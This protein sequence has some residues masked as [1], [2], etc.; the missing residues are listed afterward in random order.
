MSSS[1][2]KIK[3]IEKSGRLAVEMLRKNK[4]GMGLPF[5]INAENLP[6]TQFYYEYPDGY[7]KLVTI[8]EDRLDFKILA[9]LTMQQ[10]DD[11]RK[12]YKLVNLH[13]GLEKPIHS[14]LK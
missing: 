2:L 5:M 11:I 14:P 1:N 9:E 8:S 12:K 4:L 13:N 7:I 6:S 10:S 3:Q